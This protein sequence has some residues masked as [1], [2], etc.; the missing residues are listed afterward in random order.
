METDLNWPAIWLIGD[1]V[2]AALAH[3]HAR[4]VLHGD[5]KHGNIMVEM[6][7]KRLHCRVL[8][9]GLSW[10]LRDRFD[11]RLDGTAPE[12]PMVRPHAGTVGW[13]APEQIRGA[14][15][16]VGPATDL[17]ALGCILY[18]LLTGHEPYEAD[19]LDEIQRMHRNAPVPEVELPDDVPP[20]AAPLIQKLLA[21]RPWHRFDFAADARQVWSRL[22]PAGDPLEWDLPE[23]DHTSEQ[24]TWR[25]PSIANA[26]DMPRV[27]IRSADRISSGLFALGPAKLVGRE[28]E[29]EALRK[30]L[31]S[32]TTA[33]PGTKRLVL[34][35]GQAGV[36]KSRLAEWF[37]EETHELGYA[38]PLRAR[39]HKIPSPVDGIVGA[40]LH[41]LGI[42]NADRTV[43]ERVLLNIWEVAKEDEDSKRWVAAVA[44]WLR[45]TSA[46]QPGDIGPSGYRMVINTDE[47]RWMVIRYTLEKLGARRPLLIWLDDLHQAAPRD[48]R[49]LT[50]LA[51]ETTALR[52]LVVATVVPEESTAAPTPQLVELLQQFDST[53]MLLSPLSDVETSQLLL[54]TVPLD[55]QAMH[56]AFVRSK[57]VPL[58]ALQL[59]HAWANSGA[60]ELRDGHYCVS[61]AA[62]GALPATTSAIWDDRMASLS[63]DVRTAAMAA[64]ALGGDVR[65]EVLVPLL[66]VLQLP[67]TEA[68]TGMQ[69]AQILV[70]V[71]SS[72][73]RWPHNLLHE[74][75][76]TKLGERPDAAR[77][78]REAS[79]ALG[80]YH[81][82]ASNRRIVRHRV[83]NLIKAKEIPEAVQLM[84]NFVAKAW[85]RTRDV[86]AT[87]E[88]LALVDGLPRGAW[89]AMHKRWKAEALRHQG[90]FDDAMALALSARRAFASVNDVF[91]EAN[92]L[93]LMGHISS[94]RGAP[95]DGRQMVD[96]AR[97][98]MESINNERG[99]AQCEVVLGE[100]DYLLGNHATAVRELESAQA[101]LE[102]QQDILGRGQ[103]LILLA[104]ILMMQGEDSRARSYLVD[105]RSG[106][107]RI[108]YRL[109][110]AQCD[111]AISH[112]DHRVGE[113]EAA[114]ARG[115]NALSSFRLLGTPRGQAGSLR[116]M[117]MAALDAG[118]FHDAELKATDA[119]AT[120][121]QMGDPWGIVESKLIIAQIALAKGLPTA[122]ALL[123]ECDI[124]TVQE[125][126]PLQHWYLTRA[127]LAYREGRCEEATTALEAARDVYGDGSL[128]DHAQQ[129]FARMA[130][131]PWPEPLRARVKEAI[132]PRMVGEQA[133]TLQDAVRS[134]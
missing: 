11:H 132:L 116:L 42:E 99:Q 72:R 100:L 2:L 98:L 78:F 41:H 118:D 50:T 59:V 71:D 89:S 36:G 108:G 12:G 107:E 131:M 22:R 122:S 114:R 18:Q 119:L 29:R 27:E 123:A 53:T 76:L 124:Q 15:P 109:G 38:V 84:L 33:M 25:P 113:L 4:G 54:T 80:S 58:F 8:D 81:P 20:G 126:E 47:I 105:A 34:L 86:A 56:T 40:V 93:R 60:L 121:T 17:Y 115:Q 49:W 68:L 82:A 52:V 120:Y 133:P 117:A 31:V 74:Y 19:E 61:D 134:F 69:Q 3:A 75:L 46:Q 87:M 77:I 94:D 128:A 112:A 51:S 104:L 63:E 125:K 130:S 62:L 97:A 10:L 96:E 13:M 73:Y 14:V 48:L 57:G 39:H 85:E 66:L 23:V 44:E 67:V 92:C 129:L 65:D 45:P 90:S 30:E 55:E 5:L 37:C 70:Q 6:A 106:F 110:T 1:Q 91:N 83:T 43:I 28:K 102:R 9:F 64:S 24:T 103:C 32:L 7:N 16:H 111:V 88:D 35:S 21:K 101:A 26:P 127:W 95:R 79:H